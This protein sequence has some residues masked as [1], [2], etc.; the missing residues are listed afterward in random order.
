MVYVV[1]SFRSLAG[2][3]T[4]CN[5]CQPEKSPHSPASTLQGWRSW[6]HAACFLGLLCPTG[7]TDL[8][9]LEEFPRKYWPLQVEGCKEVREPEVLGLNLLVGSK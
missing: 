2:S 3:Q 1:F 5:T 7:C 4:A 9:G 8:G 6:S